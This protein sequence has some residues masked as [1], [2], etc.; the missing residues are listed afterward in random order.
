MYKVIAAA[1]PSLAGQ[2]ETGDSWPAWV[3]L[4]KGCFTQAGIA[5][6]FSRFI[7]HRPSAE[8]DTLAILDVGTGTG[9]YALAALKRFSNASL[10]GIDTSD[11]FVKEWTS[12]RGAD[13]LGP[14]KDRMT[15][16]R[17][18]AFHLSKPFMDRYTEAFDLITIPYVLQYSG[19]T[20]EEVR[21][22]LASL[23]A[24]YQKTLKPGGMLIV[25]LNR[26]AE[27]VRG[28]VELN[29]EYQVPA[30]SR[31]EFGHEKLFLFDNDGTKIDTLTNVPLR[32]STVGHYMFEAGFSTVETR[33]F[34][35]KK[36]GAS[37]PKPH[38]IETPASQVPWYLISA[39]KPA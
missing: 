22:N 31:R 18:D 26:L 27:G 32:P 23:M 11:T 14:D 19:D 12:G 25:T 16:Y 30:G 17:E 28:G 10:V 1:T 21:K 3:A 39:I 13:R 38:L 20:E 5:T 37:F 36:A 6:A 2:Y 4:E 24:Q 9:P 34:D 7:A 29:A 15:V 35:F 33:V 8:T